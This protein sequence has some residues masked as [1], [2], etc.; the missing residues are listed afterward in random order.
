LVDEVRAILK[1]TDETVMNLRERWADEKEYE[2]INDYKDVIQTLIP[3][4]PILKMTKVPFGFVVPI[5]GKRVH[6]TVFIK[7]NQIG[8]RAKLVR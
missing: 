2:D 4:Y 6:F 3:E 7:G 5:Q 1:K 8:T